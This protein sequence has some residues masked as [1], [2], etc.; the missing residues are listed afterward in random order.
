MPTLAVKYRPKTFEDVVEQNVIKAIL[1]N[2][3][4]N[5]NVKNCYL[6]CGPAGCGKAQPLYSKILT[7]N[8]FTTMGEIK[9]GDTVFTRQGK[10]TKVL[11]VY[12]QGKRDIYEIHFSDKTSI[13][14]ADNHLNHVFRY[15]QDKKKREDFVVNTLQLIDLFNTTRF[16]LR[17]DFPVVN[18]SHQEVPIDPYLIGAL[19]GDVGL[20]GAGCGFSNSENDV[21]EKIK[22]KVE[23]YDCKLIRKEEDKYDYRI[24][25]K[26]DDFKS[27]YTY[28]DKEYK[29][30]YK[31]IDDL[32]LEGYERFNS[33]TIYRLSENNAP[34]ILKRYPELLGRIKRYDNNNYNQ[35]NV[36][37]EKIVNLGLNVLS[38]DKF[39]PE[40]YLFND[41]E[42]RLEV[43]R[44]L[45]DTDGYT[46]SNGSTSF[47]T[48]SK[49]LS[50]DFSFLV[51]SLGC[52]D[53]VSSSETSYINTN[54]VRV[55][56]QTAYTHYIK[57]PNDMIYCS[58]NKHLKR[59]TIRQHEPMKN[60]TSISY[61][62]KEECKCIY[63]E[64][65][66][67]TYLSNDFIPTHNT[68][69]ARLFAHYLNDS[70]TNVI[71]LDAASHNGVDDVRKLIE[72]SKF[73][74]IGSKFRI[75]II[76]EAHSLSNSAWQALLKTFEEPTPT[77]IFLLCTTDPQKIP[78]T[79][80]SRVQRY[81]FQ[82]IT[83]DGIVNRL[84]YIIE[85]ENN[86]GCSYSYDEDAISYIAKL[87]DGGMRDSITLLEKTLA[88]DP[89][90]TMETVTK[91][92]GTVD[93]NTMFDLTD[94]LCK[95]DKKSVIQIVET[96]YRDGM[97]LKQFIK[98]YNYFVLDLCK[99]DIL[100]D[101]E[102]LQIPSTYSKRIHSYTK[103][104]FA[105]FVTL[106][107]EVIN[108]NT[109]IKWEATP[110]P[111]VESTFVLLCS[112]A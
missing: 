58:S 40:C 56:C 54:G 96:V 74:P 32:V 110:K 42:T 15:N 94:A 108:L 9:V 53:T 46:G 88:Y 57:F 65:E 36:L 2:Q 73:K 12:P 20:H 39:I 11:N 112:E 80:I 97:D 18:F 90:V 49:Q 79:I 61:I 78:P 98:N 55:K 106:L 31:L 83:H 51:K 82:K 37:H 44:G 50:E 111:I 69:N 47:T 95:M 22:E 8:G 63:V 26:T 71:E 86:E 91:A 17:V 107:N 100:K 62:G 24:F 68:T 81:D 43:L 38:K 7:P 89:H 77:S 103:D 48:S 84:K 102:Y 27:Y 14:V 59:R 29:G 109:S 52:R 21:I 45:F 34:L 92:L 75:Y 93:Y 6:F 60:I 76:D 67:H 101:F 30:P 16:K 66:D 35:T 41:V 85:C 33:A 5:D 105:F 64:D 99:Y 70:F 25:K 104:D 10:P 28:N 19:I 23:M 87:A 4:K 13:R 3:I 1:Q 72:D